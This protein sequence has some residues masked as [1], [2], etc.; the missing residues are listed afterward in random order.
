MSKQ[1]RDAIAFLQD[2]LG[3]RQ[4]N[5][6]VIPQKC[7]DCDVG[8]ICDEVLSICSYCLHFED[9]VDDDRICFSCSNINCKFESRFKL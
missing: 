4:N 3:I 7:R 6:K 2:P 9:H 1:I 8:D 5:E